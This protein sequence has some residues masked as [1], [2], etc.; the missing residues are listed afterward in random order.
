MSIKCDL[1]VSL[2][3]GSWN[4]RTGLVYVV[5]FLTRTVRTLSMRM[6]GLSRRIRTEID[7]LVLAFIGLIVRTLPERMCDLF[8]GKHSRSDGV[9]GLA[10]ETS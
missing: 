1:W 4:L 9:I 5:R 6:Y 3:E 2:S 10:V 8:T 7:C